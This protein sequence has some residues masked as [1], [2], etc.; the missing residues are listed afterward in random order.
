MIQTGLTSG[1]AVDERGVALSV[2]DPDRALRRVRLVQDIG[3]P[4]TA[5]EFVRSDGRWR[6]RVPRGSADRIEY[7]LELHRRDGT[8][9]VAPDP[10]NPRRVGGVFGDKSVVEFPG[11]APPAWLSSMPPPGRTAPFSVA[12]DHLR[13]QVT[14]SVWTPV[15]LGPGDLAPVLVVHDGPEYERLAALTRFLAVCVADET[16]PPLRALLLHPAERNRW[17]AAEPAYSRALME[18]VL[19]NVPASRRV[20]MGTSLGALAMLH[21]HRHDPSSFAGLFLQS[22]SFFTETLDPQERRFPRFAEITD[23]VAQV[24]D[25]GVSG[26]AI[27]IG[28]TCGSAEENLACNRLMAA[29]LAAHGHE[30]AFH[31]VPDAHNYTSWRDGF[32][33]H[34][35]ALLHAALS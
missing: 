25:S 15:G 28:M 4:A 5:V 27:P 31:L 18:E 19:P 23:F 30:V 9:E 21:A 24:H 14:G 29:R 22:G 32:D 13:A 12:S 11:Y 10:D 16:V 1:P 34:L 7:L 26:A 35:P 33:P 2:S 8:V 3:L 20:G 6:L 17:Y